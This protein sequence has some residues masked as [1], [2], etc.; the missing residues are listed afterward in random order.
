M[1][2]AW[3]A[4]ADITVFGHYTF[5]NGDTLSRASYYT[6][7]QVRTTLPNGDEIIYDDREQRLGR[8]DKQGVQGCRADA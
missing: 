4:R 8:L 3:P 2:S 7:K 6:Q 1:L 5:A